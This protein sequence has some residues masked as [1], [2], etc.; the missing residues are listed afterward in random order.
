[1]S[2][3]LASK[4]TLTLG[5]ALAL[6]PL[7]LLAIAGC[8]QIIGLDGYTVA[9]GGS[10]G[11]AGTLTNGGSAGTA[12]GGK[13]GTGGN[14][15]TGGAGAP[16]SAGASEAGAAGATAPSQSV[17][18]DGLT[19]FTAN[20]NIIRSCI[21]RAGCS[22]NTVPLRTISE[23][24]S[25]NTQAALPG[26]S[27]NLTAKSCD[28][29]NACSH[30]GI[31]HDDLCGGTKTTR[32]EN[33][34]AI[35]C[36]NY[37]VDQFSDCKAQGMTCGTYQYG[38]SKTL[39]AD[40]EVPLTPT[41]GCAGKS[42][43]LAYYCQPGSGS[44][45]DAY[46]YCYNNQAYGASCGKFASCFDTTPAQAPDGGVPEPDASCFFNFA[47]SCT[48]QPDSAV[49]NGDVAKTC[50]SQDVISYD[51]ASVGLSCATKGAN[52]YCVA[53]GCK[54]ATVDTCEESCG[55]DGVTLNFCYGGVPFS[56]DCTN[57]GFSTCMSDVKTNSD[58]TQTTYAE[59]R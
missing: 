33:G 49:C 39:Y 22:P 3:K 14:S 2:H 52:G 48:G 58:N 35:N 37:D 17:G 32:C 43:G 44:T 25:K 47:A 13:A 34:L 54:P 20:E 36:G 29:F 1:M 19:P 50:S 7:S 56:I 18:C 28:D 30:F 21:L 57:Y 38:T 23:C 12:A 11:S 45:P 26:E 24:V 59:C 51:C 41:N 53:P 16:S 27:C 31:A 6:L 9:S 8:A 55:T 4:R 42:D 10:G 46:Y 5:R 15:A 40:C